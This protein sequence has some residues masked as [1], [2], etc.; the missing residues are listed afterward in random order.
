MS[1]TL[2]GRVETLRT[3]FGLVLAPATACCA[4]RQRWSSSG[5]SKPL[6]GCGRRW[7][8]RAE[9][10]GRPGRRR[11]C[12]FTTRRVTTTK[13]SPAFGLPGILRLFFCLSVCLS[14]CLSGRA[15][16]T[17]AI[18][19]GRLRARFMA[20]TDLAPRVARRT[21]SGLLHFGVLKAATSRAPVAFAVPLKS[22]RFLFPR[23][24]PEAEADGA[25]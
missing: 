24:W 23:L 14:V 9:R 22:L 3:R 12:R 18:H 13:K 20:M 4:S 8:G 15:D 6:L 5:S 19:G 25:D 21:L 7:K 10:I 16:S 11:L 2:S 1:T 17:V